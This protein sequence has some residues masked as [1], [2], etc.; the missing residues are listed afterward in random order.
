MIK[1][2]IKYRLIYRIFAISQIIVVI[3]IFIVLELIPIRYVIVV[4]DLHI[5]EMSHAKI[6]N[7][8]DLFDDIIFSV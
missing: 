5:V 8:D 4:K 2:L 1:I 3:Y 6:V 7:M